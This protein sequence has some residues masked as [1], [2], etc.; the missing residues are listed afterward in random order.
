MVQVQKKRTPIE[1][2]R[3]QIQKRILSPVEVVILETSREAPGLKGL[4][5]VMRFVQRAIKVRSNNRI[6]QMDY[7]RFAKT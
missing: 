2:R 7:A 4:A 1:H 5:S 6:M 3:Y